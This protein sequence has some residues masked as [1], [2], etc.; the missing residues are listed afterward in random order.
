MTK[1]KNRSEICIDITDWG[2]EYQEK[3]PEIPTEDG[4]IDYQLQNGA[5]PAELGR[6]AIV[7]HERGDV[8]D[9]YLPANKLMLNMGAAVQVS[10]TIAARKKQLHFEDGRTFNAREFV[11][12]VPVDES[13]LDEPEQSIEDAMNGRELARAGSREAAHRARL[14]LRQR[15]PGYIYERLVIIAAGGGNIHDEIA[16]LK[17]EIDTMALRIEGEK[18]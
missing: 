12:Q 9:R 13:C 1:R 17:S 8:E 15:V 7:A 6:L 14:Y 16:W 3:E 4:M 5:K 10:R 18:V 2:Q 11:A